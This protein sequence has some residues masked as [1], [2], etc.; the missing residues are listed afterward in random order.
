MICPKCRTICP[1][2][3]ASKIP[4]E[5][6]MAVFCKHANVSEAKL[7]ARGSRGDAYTGNMRHLAV[8]LIRRLTGMSYPVIGA[9]MG[10]DH[11][12]LINSVRAGGWLLKERPSYLRIY[13][14]AEDELLTTIGRL[15]SLELPHVSNGTH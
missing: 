9:F 7:R 5:R 13:Q 1:C 4:P 10:R 2:E 8:L 3:K 11:S 14:A 15:P 12:T 6:I